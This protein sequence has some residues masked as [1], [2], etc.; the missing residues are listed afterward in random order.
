VPFELDI[1]EL[2]N[3][4]RGAKN[5]DLKPMEKTAAVLAAFEDNAV[6]NGLKKAQISGMREAS[7]YKPLDYPK[8]EEEL[9]RT[10]AHGVNLLQAASV[11]GPY[12]LMLGA[13][14]WQ[15]LT[16]CAQGYPLKS[17][18]EEVIG[19]P[20]IVSQN[21]DGGFLVPDQTEDLLLTLGN[22]ISIGYESHDSE[23]VK[24]YF[25]EAFTFQVLDPSVVIVLN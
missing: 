20:I 11:E 1:W 23:K 9:P 12:A 10:I 19:G 17:R 5:I 24:L 22:D 15:D 25:T 13:E 2:D 3:I 4:V 6:F 18:V 8:N 14:K 7:A 16:T 21:I